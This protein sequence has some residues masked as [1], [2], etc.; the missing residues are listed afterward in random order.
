MKDKK[1]FGAC[2][3][4]GF[5]R[6]LGR[7]PLGWH[8]WW[9]RVLGDF[10][11]GTLHYRNDVV[12]VN[13]ARSF[14][15]KKYAE[16]KSISKRFYRHFAMSSLVDDNKL[17][18]GNY[19]ETLAIIAFLSFAI[20]L[21]WRF[22]FR[23]RYLSAELEETRLMNEQLKK[24]QASPTPSERGENHPPASAP[25]VTLTGTTNETVSLEI[26]DL[27]YI[28][29]VGNYANEMMRCILR[30]SAPRCH[31]RLAQQ[32]QQAEGIAE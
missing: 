23:S 7:L 25:R 27:S 31:P 30:C 19:L 24:L 10:V 22:K 12:M 6:L 15:E 16:L 21:Y 32:C 29:A 9:G 4:G 1:T 11:R 28:E 17:S 3:A 13:L 8:R 20:G 18:L 5:L 2:L 14:P 26:A